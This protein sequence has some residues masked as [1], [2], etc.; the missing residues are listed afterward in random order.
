MNQPLSLIELD[1]GI[2]DLRI[3]EEVAVVVGG[4][5]GGVGVIGASR[6]HAGFEVLKRRRQ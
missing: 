2:R 6:S 5:G 4:G 1:S 3:E